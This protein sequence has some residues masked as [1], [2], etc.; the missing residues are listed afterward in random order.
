MASMY[1][2][3]RQYDL[4]AEASQKA[5]ELRDRVSERER[6]YIS[7]GYYDNVTGEL[8]KYLETLELWKRTYPRDASPFNNL[9]VK[10]NELGLFDKAVEAAR[11][12]IRLN[13]S[14]ASGYS[15]SAAAFVG[16]NRFD[17]AKEIIGQAQAQKLET[18][19]MRRILYRIAFVQDDATTMQQQIEWVKGKP[20]EY[21]AQ[22][23]QSET[24]AFSGQL[25]K[26]KEFSNRA[27]ELAE[28]RDL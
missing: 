11:E 16:L 22:G 6:F 12:A 1:Y 23:W 5:F 28:R 14:S 9:A 24:A 7:A 19:A 10:Y 4:A 3:S 21:V 8:E 27:F 15:L 20:D 26:A 17:E 13:P 2:N 18:T 25:Q